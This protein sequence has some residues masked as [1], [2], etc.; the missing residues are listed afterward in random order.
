VTIVG[1]APGLASALEEVA[2]HYNGRHA[3]T[4]LLIARFV[5]GRGTTFFPPA[6]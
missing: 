4:L 1:F 3:D 5:T 6:S 2:G